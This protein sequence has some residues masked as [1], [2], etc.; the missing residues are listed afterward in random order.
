MFALLFNGCGTAAV[1]T[2]VACSMSPSSIL[3]YGTFGAFVKFIHDNRGIRAGVRLFFFGVYSW[4]VMNFNYLI[5]WVRVKGQ[6]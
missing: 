2:V 5:L 4:L 1:L 3:M 6:G